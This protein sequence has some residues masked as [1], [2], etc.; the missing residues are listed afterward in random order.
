MVFPSIFSLFESKWILIEFFSRIFT[1]I[2][3]CWMTFTVGC[4]PFYSATLGFPGYHWFP[5]FVLLG[6]RT[7]VVSTTLVVG[8]FLI[9]H[10]FLLLRFSL[11]KTLADLPILECPR[12]LTFGLSS[13]KTSRFHL[14]RPNFWLLFPLSFFPSKLIH[15]YQI[16]SFPA[17]FLHGSSF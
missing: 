6:T 7:N 11:R 13:F 1:L 14:I 9:L 2:Y 3:C 12:G 17:T 5:L 4:F 10:Y 15:F 8:S 16:E